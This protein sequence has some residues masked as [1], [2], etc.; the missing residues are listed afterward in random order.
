MP[1]SKQAAAEPCS[2]SGGGLRGRNSYCRSFERSSAGVLPGSAR[3]ACSSG[4]GRP[5]RGCNESEKP[6]SRFRLPV[7]MA[8]G[9]V[10]SGGSPEPGDTNETNSAND[11]PRTSS[12]GNRRGLTARKVLP[13]PRAGDR[14]NASAR[15]CSWSTR[16]IT[17]ISPAIFVSGQPERSALN[18]GW[19]G[20]EPATDESADG[21][22]GLSGL[23]G[24]EEQARAADAPQRVVW[25]GGLR[26]V[27]AVTDCLRLPW[28]PFSPYLPNGEK[29]NYRPD[30]RGQDGEEQNDSH[31]CRE[32][33]LRRGVHAKRVERP[34]SRGTA[35]GHAGDTL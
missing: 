13:R 30:D 32:R 18:V 31:R 6:G 10:R 12:R 17:G 8:D 7:A 34:M 16:E 9:K 2:C 4:P 11:R 20:L 15:S 14:W 21:E 26:G 3:P 1:S 19:A 33:S 29:N 5:R 24:A 23:A 27:V 25:T 28:A 35:W 22:S